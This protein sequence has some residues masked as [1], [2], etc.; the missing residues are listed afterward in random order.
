MKIETKIENDQS[1]DA[2][3]NEQFYPVH[4][5]IIEN[6]W[7]NTEK[8][9][10]SESESITQTLKVTD[11][12]EYNINNFDN[13][14]ENDDSFNN[15]SPYFKA[16]RI[17]KNEDENI[18][19]I[20]PLPKNSS[21]NSS[22]NSSKLKSNFHNENIPNINRS[23]LNE[24]LPTQVQLDWEGGDDEGEGETSRWFKNDKVYGL[25]FKISLTIWTFFIIYLTF[26]KSSSF[27]L[28]PPLEKDKILEKVG[29][30]G[31]LLVIG[32]GVSAGWARVLAEQ[33]ETVVYGLILT[34]PTG[35]I[36]LGFFAF[37]HWYLVAG[38]VCLMLAGLL[39]AVVWNNKNNL[40]VTVEIV[41]TAAIFIQSTPKIYTLVLKIVAI[42]SGFVLIW[43]LGFIQLFDNNMNWSFIL[44]TSM[45]F[46]F[47][48][49]LLWVGAVLSTIQ[50]FT[51]ATWV[52]SWMNNTEDQL[53]NNNLNDEI[54]KIKLLNE[55]YF[56]SI[57]LA[58][59][60]LSTA[61]LIRFVTRTFHFSIKATGNFLNF[62]G[63][64]SEFIGWIL[65]LIIAAERLIQRF[66]DFSIYYL[67]I[68]NNVEGF[69]S[70]SQGLGKIL[71]GHIG[72]AL[73]ADSTA[74][75]LLTFSTILISFTSTALLIFIT[76]TQISWTTSALIAL[77][78]ASVTDY[79]ACTYTS[80]IDATFLC[81]LMDLRKK[82]CAGKINPQIH[83]AFSSKLE[84][85]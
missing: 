15:A 2:E 55:N 22:P 23:I 31:L 30:F 29:W 66:T 47:V 62:G 10:I 85:V 11:K 49:M 77:L 6:E 1:N 16:A 41:R 59:G 5:M 69:F 83:A 33:T 7:I 70:A 45:K 51:I 4:S 56:G 20:S 38:F 48:F 27:P 67:A 63:L 58:A 76:K 39:L 32:L 26:Y 52:R 28:L 44:T 82:D 72:L 73:T 74:Q 34:I 61:K 37:S 71:N 40:Q 35:F 25:I 57:C 13:V 64:I 68:E 19:F 81:Y 42:Y 84:S 17:N 18:R 9:T 65:S 21:P 50:K 24:L 8:I 80:A 3:E 12:S 36:G 78:A 54:I 14:N 43:L 53:N 75:L 60:I 46:L 79:V